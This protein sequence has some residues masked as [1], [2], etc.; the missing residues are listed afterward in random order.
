MI[1]NLAL[2]AGYSIEAAGKLRFRFFL[3]ILFKI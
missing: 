3:D 2:L 1:I